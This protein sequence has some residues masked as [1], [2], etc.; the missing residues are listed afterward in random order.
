MG[1]F[2]RILID[3]F[4]SVRCKGAN[5]Y[6]YR[7][8]F[9][10][11]QLERDSKLY[12]SENNAYFKIQISIDIPTKKKKKSIDMKWKKASGYHFVQVWSRKFLLLH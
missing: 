9:I 1:S 10:G 11:K 2:S 5:L 3:F 4:F 8:S 6:H 7:D 12:V